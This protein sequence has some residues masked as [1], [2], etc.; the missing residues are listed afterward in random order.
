MAQL[1]KKTFIKGEIKLLTGTH[2]GGTNSA[3]DIGGIDSTV[4]RNPIDNKPYI[5]GSSLKGKMRAMIEIADGTISINEDKYGNKSYGIS[6]EHD[7]KSSK[8]F[9]YNPK[10]SKD[11][12]Q[13]PSKLIVRDGEML[14]D[15]SEFVNTDLPYTESKTEVVIDRITAK[16]NPRQ[17]ERVP[18]GARFKLDMILNVFDE[19]TQDNQLETL[20]RALKLVQD[21][22]IGGSGSRGYGQIKFQINSVIEK[23]MD[24]Y[25]D[26]GYEGND[27]TDTWKNKL[28]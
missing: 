1:Q 26:E 24:N 18:A 6:D 19:D 5:P 15:D 17:I 16:A 4:V 23:E 20:F 3:M 2:I 22:Y 11:D 27:I 8:L 12:K 28:V 13:R 10:D 25:F 9:G 7:S 21:D 14:S